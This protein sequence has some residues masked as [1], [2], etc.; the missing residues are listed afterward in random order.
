[1][2][3]ILSIAIGSGFT[4]QFRNFVPQSGQPAATIP[5]FKFIL[6]I[7]NLFKCANQGFNITDGCFNAGD[8]TSRLHRRQNVAFKDVYTAFHFCKG[9]IG[10][11]GGILQLLIV[12]VPVGSDQTDNFTVLVFQLVQLVDL[13]VNGFF[14]I[15]LIP[16]A[17]LIIQIILSFLNSRF[18]S[19]LLVTIAGQ[20]ANCALSTGFLKFNL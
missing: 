3:N 11:L 5:T 15:F 17:L 10:N 6:N 8:R 1:M 12:I 16:L 9:H 18:V 20:F 13:I 19:Y 4:K 14:G 7:A 2:E